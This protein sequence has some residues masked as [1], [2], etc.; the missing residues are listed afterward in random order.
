MTEIEA[1]SV[2]SGSGQS[3]GDIAGSAANV[4]RVVSGLEACLDDHLLLPKPVHSEALEVV[5]YII[6]RSDG[7][8]QIP[9]FGGAICAG[10]EELA[11]HKSLGGVSVQRRRR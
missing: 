11:G 5:D 8:K 10:D 3:E 9:H 4:Q 1:D 2:G 6:S 7:G